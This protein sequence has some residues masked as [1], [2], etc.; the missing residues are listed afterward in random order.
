M[1]IPCPLW[2]ASTASCI[3]GFVLR[4]HVVDSLSLLDL[5]LDCYIYPAVLSYS[6]LVDFL[7]GTRVGLGYLFTAPAGFGSRTVVGCHSFEYPVG[8]GCWGKDAVFLALLLGLGPMVHSIVLACCR[9][10]G[11]GLA[12][13]T[14]FCLNSRHRV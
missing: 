13:C 4:Y 5:G 1:G 7:A 12:Q 14:L 6:C 8:H 11:F 3:W 9:T 2:V 10:M